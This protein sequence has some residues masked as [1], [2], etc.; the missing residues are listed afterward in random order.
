MRIL[1]LE[2]VR[3]NAV[4]V[5]ED[6]GTVEDEVRETLARF[7]ILSY[8]LL[9]FEQDATGLQARPYEYPA[10]ALASTTTHDLA[11]IAGFWTG[12]DIEAR[13]RAGTIDR[14]PAKTRRTGP[15]P[16]Q[17]DACSMPSSPMDL[18]PPDFEGDAAAHS[19]S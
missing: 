5:G 8:R 17:T 11:T 12:D 3:N 19:A 14:R 13:S 2:S 7:G 10:Q 6:L 16:R 18:L 15:H 4:I 9:I 1:A